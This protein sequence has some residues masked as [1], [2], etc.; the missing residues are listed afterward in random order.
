MSDQ[1]DVVVKLDDRVR[2]MSALLAATSYPASSQKL[3]PHGTHPHA[4][5]TR[6]YVQA[7][8]GHAAV[9]ATQGLLDQGTPLAALFALTMLMSWP[10]LEIAALPAWAP[11]RYNKLLLSFYTDAD[12]AG[13]WRAED[14]QWQKALN[15]SQD[16]FRNVSFRPFFEP[17]VEK[18]E[19]GLVFIPN[20]SYPTDKDIGF[21][22]GNQLIAICPPPLAWGDSPPW[23]YNE[24]TMVTQSLRAAIMVYGRE[25]IIP[26]LREHIDQLAEVMETELPVTDQFR[27][28]YP[29][30]DDQFV[31]LFLSAAVA[32]YLEDHVDEKE[33]Q[34]YMLMEKKARGMSI[35][36]GT[37]SV[38]R[39]YL[40][41]KDSSSKYSNLIEFLPIF[42]KQLRVAQKIVRF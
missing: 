5:A 30:W 28:Q 15:Q 13:L 19:E 16:V 32:M 6:K 38:L 14:E 25:L 7:H 2:L 36:P 4:R 40:Q 22:L 18:V 17:F 42:P 41:E 21:K 20:I 34:S 33:F 29:A 24:A 37:V 1:G 26:Y 23:P 31:A 39:R 12:L 35:L 9:E 27:A 3:K 10:E 8:S 11:S